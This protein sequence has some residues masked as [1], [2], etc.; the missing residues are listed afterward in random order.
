MRELPLLDDTQKQEEPM[1]SLFLLLQTGESPKRGH[2]DDSEGILEVLG[3]FSLKK[4]RLRGTSSQYSS[5]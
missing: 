2:E 4:I 1:F 3:V 5:M